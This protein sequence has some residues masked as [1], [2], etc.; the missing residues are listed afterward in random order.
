MPAPDDTIGSIVGGY[1]GAAFSHRSDGGQLGLG[2]IG[3]T[4][5]YTP[6]GGPCFP[7]DTYALGGYCFRTISLHIRYKGEPRSARRHY[8]AVGGVGAKRNRLHGE[9]LAALNLMPRIGP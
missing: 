1:Y 2:T 3:S 8:I 4:A 6:T 7:K 9:N 5:H